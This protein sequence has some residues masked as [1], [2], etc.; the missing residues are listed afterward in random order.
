MLIEAKFYLEQ[1][2]ILEC[3]F[4]NGNSIGLQT[5]IALEMIAVDHE[6]K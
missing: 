1:F 4:M 5:F 3:E 2:C 6:G